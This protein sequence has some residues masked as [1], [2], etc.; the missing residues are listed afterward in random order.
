VQTP[1]RIPQKF[2]SHPITGVKVV[3]IYAAQA[4]LRAAQAAGLLGARV[5]LT[6]IQAE[7]AQSLVHIG[8]DLSGVVTR[9][10]LR[11][12]IAYVLNRR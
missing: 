4:L 7:V 3:D 8:A 11:A 5:I 1:W 12:G 9:S 6:G 2:E 10:D